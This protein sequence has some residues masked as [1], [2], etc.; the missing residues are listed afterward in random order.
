MLHTGQHRGQSGASAGTETKRLHLK[1]LRVKKKEWV[2][3]VLAQFSQRVG[4]DTNVRAR[5]VC[6]LWECVE[7]CKG[8]CRE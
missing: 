4:Y 1:W 5:C 3:V 8:V 7:I 2:D 6:V